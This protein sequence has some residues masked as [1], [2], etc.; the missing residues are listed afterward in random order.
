[1]SSRL[2]ANR[3]AAAPGVSPEGAGGRLDGGCDLV[4]GGTDTH[5]MLV[6]LRKKGVTVTFSA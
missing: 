4:S 3:D 1:M 2:P 6:D 5:L